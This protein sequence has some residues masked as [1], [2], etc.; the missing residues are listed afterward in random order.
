MSI[1]STIPVYLLSNPIA[2]KKI[3]NGAYGENSEFDDEFWE[4]AAH[5]AFINRDSSR[6]DHVFN[7]RW[8]KLKADAK[9]NGAFDLLY[10][11]KCAG[12]DYLEEKNGLIYVKPGAPFIRWQNIRSRMSTFPIKLY[13][14]HRHKLPL[15]HA[16]EYSS[17]PIWNEL[18]HPYSPSL[19]DHI[20]YEG[21]NETH[22]HINAYASPDDC[23]LYFLCHIKEFADGEKRNIKKG[24]ARILYMRID[25]DLTP[26]RVA[27]HLV[28]A[29]ILRDAILKILDCAETD[30]EA[31]RDA[32]KDAK[33]ALNFIRISQD[34]YFCKPKSTMPGDAEARQKQEAGMWN[35]AFKRLENPNYRYT[36]ALSWALHLYLL[37]QNEFIRLFFHYERYRGFECFDTIS[38]QNRPFVGSK[39]YYKT[40]IKRILSATHAQ[41]KNV[42][43]FRLSPR[44]LIKN[45]RI[46]IESWYDEWSRRQKQ[47]GNMQNR[48]TA[49]PP[50]LVLVAHFIKK[51]C[52]S[53]KS[54][55]ELIVP[56]LYAAESKTHMEEAAA[57]ATHAMGIIKKGVLSLGIDAAGDELLRPPEVFAPAFRLFA[58]RTHIH[59]K[60]FHCGEDFLHL[61]SGMR[62]IYE[63]VEFLDLGC[64]S[65][66][67]HAT[68][69]G[70][71]PKKWIASMPSLIIMTRRE[72]LLNLIFIRRFLKDVETCRK[73]ES[74]IAKEAKHIFCDEWSPE[75]IDLYT[76]DSMFDARKLSLK[77]LSYTFTPI[78]ED[79]K[80]E[81]KL[82]DQFKEKH[83]EAPLQLY[84][85]WRLDPHVR[86]RQNEL[87]EVPV[88]Y[89]GEQ[90]L[91]QL[92]QVIQ[93]R[94]CD[95]EIAVESLL[96][97][98]LRISQYEDIGQHHLL[99]WLGIRGYEVPG[100]AA[101]N[102]CLGSDDP[103]IFVTDI[104]NEYY[105]LY[106]IL[107][108]I[109][110]S[111]SEAMDHIKRIHTTGR[112][113]SF[114]T[115]PGRNPEIE[116][117]AKK[118]S[119]FSLL[120]EY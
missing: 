55:S 11:L 78:S 5:T 16:L 119:L 91:I 20:R 84:K 48:N 70:I 63:A 83:S 64:G 75:E 37:I 98:N 112:I 67:G 17:T 40:A 90:L 114:A 93:H 38:S 66:I 51:A 9:K 4:N 44:S 71:H 27:N 6:P 28:F 58:R 80:E 49:R 12:D 111:S 33:E 42:I 105:H 102:V 52:C 118:T 36:K 31:H 39:S 8:E 85:R 92:Q 14:L 1:V 57:F 61:I 109:G 62:A 25:T 101:L 100:D 10:I 104:K 69:I 24:K 22:L 13:F 60:T 95:R 34:I 53:E 59:H 26:T 110:I 15:K 47:Y 117:N 120:D 50:Q 115:L 35:R 113:Y 43:E 82:C 2:L 72:W 99:R 103:G 73:V 46:F 86:R 89:L 32:I 76:L 81:K 94:L 21:I 116:R 65:R 107:Q 68:A 79:G 45:K 97:S 19:S 30:E 56:E 74:D 54:G 88:D 106:N 23:W 29:R 7:K 96:T 77:Y 108:H 3:L 41:E 87:V 18:A